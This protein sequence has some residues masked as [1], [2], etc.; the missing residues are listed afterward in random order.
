MSPTG[1][2]ARPRTG[3]SDCVVSGGGRHSVPCPRTSGGTPTCSSPTSSAAALD[4]ASYPGAPPDAKPAPTV[5]KG[6]NDDEIVI[7]RANGEVFVVKRRVRAKVFTRPGRPR[8]GFCSDDDRVFS[9]L[10][11]CEGTQG[12][13]EVGANVQGAFKDLINKVFTQIN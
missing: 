2:A 4:E 5:T 12:T 11:W 8:V 1:R 6:D 9:R 13:I 10:A 3:D 7:T